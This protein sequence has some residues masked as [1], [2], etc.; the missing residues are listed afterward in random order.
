MNHEMEGDLEGGANCLI[1]ILL[2]RLHGKTEENHVDLIT[3]K[4][5]SGLIFEPMTSGM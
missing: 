1:D 2:R 5:V 3:E 4:A